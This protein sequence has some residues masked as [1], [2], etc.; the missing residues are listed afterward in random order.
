MTNDVIVVLDCGA[1]NIRAIAVDVVG[2]IVAKSVV[3]N[4]TQAANENPAWHI[5]SLDEILG[6]F[7][8]CC[9]AI[10]KNLDAS[11]H[12]IVGLTVTTFGV[13]G[14]LLDAQGAMLYPVISWKCPRTVSTMNNIRR[15]FEPADLQRISGVGHFSFNTLYKLIWLKENRP[16]ILEQAAHWLFISSMITHYLTGVLSTDRTMAGTSQMFDLATDRF[17]AEILERIGIP[18]TLFPA[19]VNPGDE[20]IY[21]EPC[22]VSYSPSI[23][24]AHGVPVGGE[25]D[26][27]D[28]LFDALL[29]KDVVK[30]HRVKFSTQIGNLGAH[31]LNNFAN[32]YTVRKL[33]E[34]LN[35]K[36]ATTTEKYINYL[37]EAYLLFSLLR[38]SPKS[39]ERIKSPRKV[40]AVDNGFV[41]A[42]AIQHSPDKGRLMEN[43]VFIELVK[44][45]IKPNKDLFYYKTRNNREVDFVVKKGTD[46]SELIQVCYG[47]LTSDVEQREIKA[48]FEAG[49]E[50]KVTTLTVLTWDESREVK[51]DSLVVRFMPLWKWLLKKTADV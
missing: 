3:P 23:A 35:L 37:E 1:T 10:R 42:K 15:Y 5:W 11:G 29:F 47:T 33:L 17:S 50:L 13:D 27:L 40:Y 30:R 25:L 51:Q 4:A 45:G 2:K 14:A 36:S 28:V 7:A 8:Q 31:L 16:D 9:A 12:H 41:T 22:Y 18:D 32:L 48:L 20:I 19:I 24:M 39:R 46:V 34:I 6:K 26:Y 44:R 43:M 49:G 21:H 38:Y